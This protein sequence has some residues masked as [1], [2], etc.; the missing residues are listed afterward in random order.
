MMENEGRSEDQQ[1]GRAAGREIEDM[2]AA[3]NLGAAGAGDRIGPYKLVEEVGEGGMGTVWLAQQSEPVRRRVALKIVKLGMD[4]REVVARFEAE[5]QA[6]ALMDHPGIAKVFDAGATE[7][8]RPFFVMELVSGVPI[9]EYCDQAKLDIEAR[10]ELFCLVC[11]AIQHAHHKGIIHRDVKPSNVLVRMQDSDPVPKV[12]D[13]GIAKATSSELTDQSIHTQ[14]SQV[15]GT[16][17]YMAPEQAQKGGM[18]ID[19]RADVYSL[20]VLL[21]ELLTGTKPF[22][23]KKTLQTG[24]AEVLRKICEDDPE[25]PSTRVSDLRESSDSIARMRRTE[26]RLLCSS[27]KGDLDWIVMRA[28]EKDR[29]RRYETVSG[30]AGDIRSHLKSEPVAAAPPSTVYRLSKMVKRHKRALA[31]AA[32]ALVLLVAG[33]I[34][35]GLGWFKTRQANRALDV[36]LT[37]KASALVQEE[38]QRI[39]AE[40]SAD[41]AHR[42]ESKAQQEAERAVLAE[43]VAEERADDLW[44]VVQF[45]VNQLSDIDPSLMGSN[46][47][48]EL[49]AA[50]GDV[51]RGAVEQS[52]TKVN[53]TDLAVDALRKSFFEP[54]LMNIEEQFAEQPL[55]QAQLLSSTS[56]TMANLGMVAMSD[57]PIRRALE[58]QREE[59]GPESEEALRSLESLASVLVLAG[60]Y[61]EAE[62][63]CKE[64]LEI[65]RRIHGNEDRRTLE[66]M[67]VLEDLYYQSMD[68]ASGVAIAREAYEISVGLLGKDDLLTLAAQNRMARSLHHVGK[69][70]EGEALSWF[71]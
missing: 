24:Y 54:G 33:T 47:R 15:M 40:E 2:S 57:Q 66:A 17:E 32:L 9:T 67:L 36:A 53:F 25:T 35:T 51:D 55:V 43:S 18:D 38:Q 41:R 44:R 50:V 70:G 29:T 26:G 46:L 1:A 62:P 14:L 27:L 59:L 65:C 63:L 21:Y 56:T 49:L 37:A 39:A 71:T 28:L 4:T 64:Y 34:G 5:R 10:L 16:P 7:S 13:F 3:S 6:L 12:I 19:T 11:E 68:T 69:R 31:F 61:Q 52:L 45:Q 42:A 8:G 23:L 30:L 20:G 58:I 60:R 48:D 22:D